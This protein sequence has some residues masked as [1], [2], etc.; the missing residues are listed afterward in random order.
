MLDGEWLSYPEAAKRLQITEDAIHQSVRADRMRERRGLDGRPVVWVGRHTVSA[1]QGPSTPEGG[2][3]LIVPAQSGPT[4][5]SPPGN[6]QAGAALP[7]AP[8]ED[9]QPVPTAKAEGDTAPEPH[10]EPA[11]A[12]PSVAAA[13]GALQAAFRDDL[14]R[15]ESR[16]QEEIRRL[17]ELHHTQVG[18]LLERVDAAEIRAESLQDVVDKLSQAVPQVEALAGVSPDAL[19]ELVAAR[20]AELLPDAEAFKA[21]HGQLETLLVRFAEQLETQQARLGGNEK[22][23]E[24][25]QGLIDRLGERRQR[26]GASSDELGAIDQ[27]ISALTDRLSE[28]LADDPRRGQPASDVIQKL[29][30][31]LANIG[32]RLFAQDTQMSDFSALVGRLERLGG[33]LDEATR[34][35]QAESGAPVAAALSAEQVAPIKDAIDQILGKLSEQQTRLDQTQSLGQTLTTLVEDV[36][37]QRAVYETANQNVETMARE[38]QALKTEMGGRLAEQKEALQAVQS[39]KDQYQSLTETLTKKPETAETPAA[40]SGEGTE[41]QTAAGSAFPMMFPP[42]WFMLGR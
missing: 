5:A 4:Q 34:A 3:T 28:S 27:R 32:E 38:L 25:L 21:A 16:Y 24:Q 10:A 29:E 1:L 15:V 35:R 41:P 36:R 23:G 30:A 26:F 19:A 42:F 22:L 12:D 11:T 20:I 6:G 17:Q 31:A 18:L 14:A 2:G 39:L 9:A 33:S 8:K 7:A 40:G 37:T 13:I